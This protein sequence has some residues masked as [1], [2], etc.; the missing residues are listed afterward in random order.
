MTAKPFNFRI[1]PIGPEHS[2]KKIDWSIYRAFVADVYSLKPNTQAL[3]DIPIPKSGDRVMRANKQGPYEASH[4]IERQIS[5][6]RRA[7][8]KHEPPFS[9]KITLPERARKL[10]RNHRD[11]TFTIK[12][13]RGRDL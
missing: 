5:R 10:V 11:K 1:G 6:L 2:Q 12:I 3:M 9:L 7:A 8:Q 4:A 13:R